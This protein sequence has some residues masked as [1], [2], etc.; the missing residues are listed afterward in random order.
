MVDS[1][2][3]IRRGSK[4][5]VREAETKELGGK[6]DKHQVASSGTAVTG[7][8]RSGAKKH[9][10]ATPEGSRGFCRFKSPLEEINT[11]PISVG[12]P[13]AM[14]RPVDRVPFPT[15]TGRETNLSD[16]RHRVER[17]LRD[18]TR[19]ARKLHLVYPE[20][21]REVRMHRLA[22]RIAKIRGEISEYRLHLSERGQDTH[23]ARRTLSMLTRACDAARRELTM[24]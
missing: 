23:H 24:F 13:E 2:G 22:S 19:E 14:P 10:P 8:Y 18:I 21:I 12:R 5:I 15:R 3:S 20:R 16:F 6:K 7:S 9:L 11:T 4:P 17:E 1:A